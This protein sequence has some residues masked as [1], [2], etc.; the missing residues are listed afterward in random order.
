MGVDKDFSKIV[1][2]SYD[3]FA[4]G[5]LIEMDERLAFRESPHMFAHIVN[6]FLESNLTFIQRKTTEGKV[7]SGKRKKRKAKIKSKVKS[8]RKKGN[9]PTTETSRRTKGKDYR[10]TLNMKR[11]IKV[12]KNQFSR[13]KSKKTR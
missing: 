8:L 11:K 2:W 9:Q 13:K 7:K 5:K 1:P 4:D 12:N 10:K 6:P 3:Y